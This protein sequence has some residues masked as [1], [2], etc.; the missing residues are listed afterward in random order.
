MRMP[1]LLVGFVLAGCGP[2]ASDPVCDEYILAVEAHDDA[3]GADTDTTSF[4]AGGACWDNADNADLCEQAC[5]AG[6][7]WL[8]RSSPGQATD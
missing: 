2:V 7:G 1:I 5:A 6:L 4:A 8:E 3:T